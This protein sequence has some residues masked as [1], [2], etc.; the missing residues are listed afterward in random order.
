MRKSIRFAAGIIFLLVLYTG[1]VS[2]TFFLSSQVTIYSALGL[3]PL[4][5][6]IMNSLFGL[7]L[8]GGLFCL[9]RFNHMGRK[10]QFFMKTQNAIEKIG[11][12]DFNVKLQLEF[13]V[14][15]EFEELMESVNN[16][17]LE[18]SQLEKMRQEF[19]S[20]VSHEIQ[21]PL[22]SI[23]GFAHALRNDELSA[24]ERLRYVEIIEA[25]SSRL[26]QLSDSMLKL[27]YLE[28][29]NRKFELTYFRLDQQIKD[30]ILAC[31]PQWATKNI[32][33][34]VDVEEMS[35]NANKDLL[36][37]VWTN[38]IHNSLKFTSEGGKV[39]VELSR[40]GNSAICRISDTGI[41]M[42]AEDQLHVFERFYKADKSRERSHGG[43]GLGLS[44]AKKIVDIHEGTIGVQSVLG[45]G[46]TFTVTLLTGK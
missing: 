9:L 24:E 21:S 27:A 39:R 7:F 11:A 31:E 18:L 12:G 3:S 5:I 40:Q 42:S 16:M 30:I 46:T 43:N 45:T 37:Q 20:N 6:Q 10:K 26:S 41:G 32:D 1:C 34:E 35:I 28:A 36:N 19:I 38:I 13:N 33:M 8:A 22:T 15:K 44:I 4:F 14:H 23:R 29:E 2:I 25:E 17:A